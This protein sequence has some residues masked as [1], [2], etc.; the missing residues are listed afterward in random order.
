MRGIRVLSAAVTIVMLLGL[1]LGIVWAQG[2]E[3]AGSTAA[4]PL[5]TGFTY[6]GQLNQ[7]GNPVNDTCAVQYSLW[8][9][10]EDGVQ[11]GATLSH[12]IVSIS[13]GFFTDNLDFGGVFTGEAR[14]L[15]VAVKCTGDADY[16]T[17]TPRQPLT[18][19][20]YAL[21]LIPGA[22]ISGS[23]YQNL[24]VMSWA[25]TGGIPAGVTGEIRV[26]EDGTGLYGS[27][28]VSTAG[29]TGTG[30]WG[31]TWSPLGSGVKG[32]GINGAGGVYGETDSGIGVT[33]Y[34]T[35]TT[36]Y[37]YGVFGTS[38]SSTGT[39]IAGAADD[40]NCS[41]SWL[42]HCSGVTGSSSH[43]YGV[44]ATTVDGAALSADVSGSG[45]G[46]TLFS[47]VGTG[48]FI[49]ASRYIFG[50]DTE[51]KVTNDGEVYAD[52]TFHTP[53]ADMAELLPAAE[54]L[55]A[56]DVL[57]IGPDGQLARCT[58][59]YQATV[60]GVYSTQPGFVGGSAD[61]EETNQGKVPLAVVGV[62][63]VKVSVEN[64][65]IQPGDLLVAGSTPGHAM[66]AGDKL[67]I[68]TVIGKAL[69]GLEEGTGVILM[70]VVLQ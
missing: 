69:E 41:A 66:R 9:A 34:A 57:C 47:E 56:G 11:V 31:R 26:A 65:S 4:S 68:G 51:F 28:T 23:A 8:D 43:G 55:E 21:G 33:G 45:T 19:A 38:A 59:P 50:T 48:D 44:Y 16:V 46:L 14:W 1:G 15:Q 53:A 58:Q 64:G 52:G 30:V 3:P 61:Q 29:S 22:R 5:G 10:L 67:A 63:P 49:S 70:L 39:G 60:V 25:P 35:A 40:A 37:T 12:D 13:N 6:Q 62:V 20:P 17:L 36:G 24:K 18:A 7:D 27:N 42:N 54:G 32:T 2:P